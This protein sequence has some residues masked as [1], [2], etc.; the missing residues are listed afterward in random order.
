MSE[1]S[2]R[3]DDPMPVIEIC[4]ATLDVDSEAANRLEAHLAPD[5]LSRAAR[6]RFE[7]DRR[8]FVVRR[9]LLREWLASRI[10]GEPRSLVFDASELGKPALRGGECQFNLSHSH[11]SLMVAMSDIDV[12][13]DVER[14]D[15]DLEWLPIAKSF[16]SHEVVDELSRLPEPDACRAFFQAWTRLEACAKAA[17]TGL[18]QAGVLTPKDASVNSAGV[19]ESPWDVAD[20]FAL[21]GYAAAIATAKDRGALSIAVRHHREIAR[22]DPSPDQSGHAAPLASAAT[23]SRA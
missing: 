16:F 21:D 23:A 20:L 9:G 6:F 17:G 22:A 19:I 8:R 3:P 12:G 4:F 13:C 5:E 2:A 11:E 14:L 1:S 15:P 18:A 10:G 7:R